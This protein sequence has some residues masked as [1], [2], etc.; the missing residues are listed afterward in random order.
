METADD[1]AVCRQFDPRY[2]QGFVFGR[3]VKRPLAGEVYDRR[4]AEAQS[5]P[6]DDPAAQA[7]TA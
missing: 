7:A 6:A 1:L 4:L 3:P 5:Q 2:L